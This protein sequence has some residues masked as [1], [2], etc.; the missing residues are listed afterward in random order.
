M[1][2]LGGVQNMSCEVL[3]LYLMDACL[4]GL[5]SLNS[6]EALSLDIV[7]MKQFIAVE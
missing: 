3:E 5:V 1:T 4:S 2:K 7:R 6:G